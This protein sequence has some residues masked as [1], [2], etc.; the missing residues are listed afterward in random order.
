MVPYIVLHH[1]KDG[2]ENDEEKKT[3]VTDVQPVMG[4]NP[5]MPSKWGYHKIPVDL[6]QVPE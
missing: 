1:S 6:R 5:M 4:K 3:L 2:L